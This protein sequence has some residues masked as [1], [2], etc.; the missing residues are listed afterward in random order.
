VNSRIG[1]AL[2]VVGVVLAVGTGGLVFLLLRQQE[3]RA[4]ERAR[5]EAQAVAAPVAATM[6]LPVAARP[7]APGAVISSEDLLLKDFPLDLVPVAAITETLV[8]ENQIAATAIGQGET[9]SSRQLAGDSAVQVSQQAPPG[10]VIF[11]YP[12]ADLLTSSN[13]VHDGDRIDLLITMPISS[14]DTGGSATFFTLQSIEVFRVLREAAPP[15]EEG[16][17]AQAGPATALLLA[18]SPEDAVIIKHVKD[19][20]GVIDFVLRSIADDEPFEAPVI[21]KN[22]IIERYAR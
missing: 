8:L 20:G 1:W 6:K 15:A 17:P 2:V 3:A 4:L 9:I 5:A 22:E 11:A 12:V 16:Q 10:K 21:D 19:S 7:I 13:I 18:L 14:T